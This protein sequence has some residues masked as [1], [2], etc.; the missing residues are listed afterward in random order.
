MSKRLI[1]TSEGEKRKKHRIER[2][3]DDKYCELKSLYASNDGANKCIFYVFHVVDL[4]LYCASALESFVFYFYFCSYSLSLKPPNSSFHTW[5]FFF[6]SCDLI[7]FIWCLSIP[8]EA[9]N[10]QCRHVSCHWIWQWFLQLCAIALMSK[11]I[12]PVEKSVK[13]SYIHQR[14]SQSELNRIENGFLRRSISCLW[15][16]LQIYLNARFVQSTV[17]H[18]NFETQLRN[19]QLR[20]C[21]FEDKF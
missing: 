3:N 8:T 18:V 14:C 12:L 11:T 4:R 6:F 21:Q 5:A 10:V 19:V 13:S 16:W 17:K 1:R 20:C 15:T 7:H 2:L 9:F